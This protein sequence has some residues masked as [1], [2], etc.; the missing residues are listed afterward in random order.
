MKFTKKELQEL[1]FALREY[2][3]TLHEENYE[4][5]NK[6]IKFYNCLEN[7][8]QEKLKGVN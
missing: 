7:K 2:C 8:I 6:N 1:Q 3:Q 5:Y 4:Y